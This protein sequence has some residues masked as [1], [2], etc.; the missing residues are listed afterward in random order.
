MVPPDCSFHFHTRATNSSR[1]RSVRL[2]ALGVELALHHHLGGDAGVVRARLPQRVVAAHAVV[3]REHVHERVLEG[4]AH[5]QRAGDVRRR[6]R[7]GVGRA[8]PAGRE[9]AIGFPTLVDSPLDLVR[10]VD[11]FHRPA[12]CL[13][14]A[15]L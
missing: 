2:L 9:P 5:V 11:L 7:D 1:V 4:M 10:R 14:S 8:L 13:R 15:G 6:N 3:A 12:Q